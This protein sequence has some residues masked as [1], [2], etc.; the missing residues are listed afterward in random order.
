VLI[1]QLPARIAYRDF[2]LLH[3]DPSHAERMALTTLEIVA[4][5]RD[6]LNELDFVIMPEGSVTL[7]IL[8]QALKI[9]A[10]RFRPNTVTCLGLQ[11]ISLN[12]Y[13]ELLNTYRDDNTEAYEAVEGNANRDEDRKP[14]N[15]GVIA[16]K[17]DDGRLACFLEAKTHPYAGEEFFDE[18]RDLFRGR[19]FYLIRSS[20]IPFNFIPLIC[21][22]YIYREITTSNIQLIIERANELYLQSRQHLDLLIVIQCN[23]KPEHRAF[24]E[25]VNGF[26]GEYL[27]STPGVRNTVTCFCNTSADSTLPGTHHPDAF[28]ASSII[29]S[30]HHKIQ[31]LSLGE[32]SIDTFFDAPV[33][34]L[35]F[36]G[37][38][39]LFHVSIAP[40]HEPDPRKSRV[41]LKVLGI[42]R[43]AIDDDG[44]EKL[45]SEEVIHGTTEK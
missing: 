7:N 5:G 42:F 2:K 24:W 11:H 3:I 25:V 43:P 34:R 38:T 31:K 17:D 12:E 23:P 29:M 26:Y 16:V 39:R 44:W 15:C 45:S 13:V 22:D 10:E 9:I 19:H 18:S 41:P 32:F 14:V 30:H 4:E 40:F 1:A 27:A 35:R 37:A 21:L 20:L 6:G 28:G 8:P 36:S 33:R